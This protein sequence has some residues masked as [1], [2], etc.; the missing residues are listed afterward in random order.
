MRSPPPDADRR[1]TQPPPAGA[2]GP[3]DD[4]HEPLADLAREA[5]A[6]LHDAGRA[7][8]PWAAWVMLVVAI[9]SSAS[10]TSL[11]A[12]TAGF[13]RPGPTL[14]MALCYLV[15]FVALTRALRVIPVSIAYAIWSGLGMTLVS[16]IG[17]VA[18]DQRLGGAELFGIGLIL[19]GV[20]LIQLRSR[21]GRGE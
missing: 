3:D 5:G 11:L 13:T 19:A 10:G 17:W 7:R 20:L 1:P 15:C 4:V 16:V 2:P 14:A 8:R 9:T 6:R 18:F 21:V 12:T